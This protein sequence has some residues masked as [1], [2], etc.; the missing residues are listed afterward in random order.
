MVDELRV[1]RLAC[2]L[3]PIRFSMNRFDNYD[4]KA[5]NLRIKRG[6]RFK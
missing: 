6:A 3:M 2:R 5:N 1:Y 4:F